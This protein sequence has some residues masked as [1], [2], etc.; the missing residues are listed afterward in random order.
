[1][2]DQA[3]I[4][5]NE[6]A[7]TPWTQPSSPLLLC[8]T[9][10][11]SFDPLRDVLG[12]PLF[13]SIIVFEGGLGTW[14]YRN[15]E[16]FALGTRMLDLLHVP[17]HR[18]AF[19][20][21]VEQSLAGLDSAILNAA[22]EEL[23]GKSLSDLLQSFL[24]LQEAFTAFYK[25]GAFVEPVQIAAQPTLSTTIERLS[26]E[27]AQPIDLTAEALYC[28]DQPSY[29]LLDERVL[30]DVITTILGELDATSESRRLQDMPLQ[31]A[32]AFLQA[33]DEARPDLIALLN[34]YVGTH[35]WV[36]NTYANCDPLT[37]EQFVD[38]DLSALGSSLREASTNV[39]SQIASVE[40]TRQR[41]QENKSHL[42][43]HL[44]RTER[45]LLSIHE[46][47]GGW[48]LDIRKMMV[49]RTNA[50]FWS[51]LGAMAP[52]LDVSRSELLLLLPQELP[53]F[54]DH[55]S[56][57]RSRL[58]ARKDSVV[59]YQ[60]D[61]SVL[62]E[63]VFDWATGFQKMDGPVI[64]EGYDGKTE[65]L[66]VLG[67]R[68]SCLQSDPSDEGLVRG[69]VIFRDPEGDSTRG[70]V[71]VVRDPRGVRFRDGD[72]LVTSSTTPEFVP[73][74]RRAAAVVTDW[75]GQTSH[76]AIICRELRIPC[77]VGTNYG[78]FTFKSGDEVVID[79][80]QGVVQ[81]ALH[82]SV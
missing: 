49:K 70:V 12:A 11:P 33:L 73:V 2:T 44:S 68:L 60:G 22:G 30:S 14:A 69:D 80:T 56:S 15:S 39:L 10:V 23:A 31:P 46:A 82:E 50:C 6:Q 41:L 25:F 76:A 20:E 57:F 72:I 67:E 26:K 55:P 36:N 62:D 4:R 8:L 7:W 27:L 75:G 71:S 54:I 28:L 40:A 9:V 5:W 21:G 24:T 32:L 65:L 45:Q 47:V 59:V 52:L 38:V 35:H 77:I 63:D 42:L 51:I 66:E 53:T 37:A 74:M 1:M 48:L 43:T 61:V 17:G 18:R 19:D 3:P 29:V 79:W 34:E 78:S 58:D 16:A 13:T 64:S 81:S